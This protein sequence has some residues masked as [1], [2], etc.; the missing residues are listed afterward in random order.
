MNAFP[1]ITRGRIVVFGLAFWY[2]LAG[3]TYQFLHYLIG[4]RRLGWDVYYVED[5]SREVYDV[6]TEDYTYDWAATGNIERIGGVLDAHGFAGKWVANCRIHEQIWGM[7]LAELAEVYRTADA[8]LHVC[9]GQE[10]LDEHMRIPRRIY[11]ET[12]PVITQ[13]RV[14]EGNVDV[15]E[16][17]DAHDTHFSYGE[18]FGA[19]D[20]RVPI[21][22]YTWLPT[23]QPVALE[24]WPWVESP[25]TAYTTIATWDNKGN[26]VAWNG[27][28]YHWS[29]RPEYMKI[30]DLPRRRDV[31]MEMASGVPAEDAAI[32]D[33]HGWHRRDPVSV[34][35]DIDVYRDYISGARA[36]MSVAKDQNIRLRSGW[37]SDRSCCFLAAGRPVITQDTAFGNVMPTGR[38]L[39]SFQT[40][41]DILAAIDAIESDYEGNRKAALEIAHEYFSAEKVMS[42]ICERAGL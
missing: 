33:Q 21:E 1:P 27:E 10:M 25:G 31:M 23:R 16:T 4:L 12:D 22:K 9:V 42:S 35:K 8:I 29:K 26:D 34:S 20:C 36:E 37:F 39:F 38:G 3:V 13:I 28:V 30:I 6:A 18:N 24:L 5:S 15:I 2:P 17:L 32:M 41:D 19:T 14:A 40:K 11:V 7:T